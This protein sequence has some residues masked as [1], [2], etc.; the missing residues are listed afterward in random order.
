MPLR[1]PE[2]SR[3]VMLVQALART[4]TYS[5]S[6]CA[7]R[8]KAYAAVLLRQQ[9]PALDQQAVSL[10]ARSYTELLC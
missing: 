1:Q 5:S 8:V 2:H 10:D 7:A 4:P 9:A 6:N 3:L